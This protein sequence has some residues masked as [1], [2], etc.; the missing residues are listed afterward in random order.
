EVRRRLSGAVSSDPAAKPFAK[1]D[2]AFA[3]TTQNA[4]PEAG[5]AESTIS[6]VRFLASRACFSFSA[7]RLTGSLEATE[8]M[9]SMTIE[10]WSEHAATA[11]R[12]R[13]KTVVAPASFKNS[14]RCIA[15]SGFVV[16]RLDPSA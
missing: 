10:T 4:E 11:P 16:I 3:T 5:S 15:E 13:L 6:Q 9:A 12:A 8:C 1:G 14:L 7:A 2:A